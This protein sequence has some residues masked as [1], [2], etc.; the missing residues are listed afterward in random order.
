MTARSPELNNITTTA[1]LSTLPLFSGKLCDEGN[2]PSGGDAPH[3]VRGAAGGGSPLDSYSE[4]LTEQLEITRGMN[5]CFREYGDGLV[6]ATWNH[7]IR[8]RGG[9][10]S[11]RGESEFFELN[12]IRSQKRARSILT[13]KIINGK[14]DHMLTLTYRENKENLLDALADLTRFCNRVQ[15]VI[16]GWDYAVT[17]ERQKR[18]AIHFH[19]AVRGWQ[20]VILLRE[21][22]L[23]IVGEG[24]IDVRAPSRM[25]GNS[26]WDRVR[27]ARYLSKYLTK[28]AGTDYRLNKKTYWHS[29]GV[30]DPPVTRIPCE[31]GKALGWAR[32]MV[33]PVEGRK[34]SEW[35]T[36]EGLVGRVANF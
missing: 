24:N 34:M 18:G 8:R 19:L 29:D 26:T 13:R 25:T 6:E 32:E 4:H 14:L 16:P 5:L 1:D 31:H 3:A 33:K 23:S 2:A 27:L 9:E 36:Y 11:R 30:D 21:I 35:S 22:W 12:L 15:A 10:K 7:Q 28:M 20:K 17:W